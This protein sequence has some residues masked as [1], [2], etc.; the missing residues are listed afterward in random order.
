MAESWK[1]QLTAQSL[2]TPSWSRSISEH[3]RRLQ[4]LLRE[5]REM[6]QGWGGGDLDGEVPWLRWGSPYFEYVQISLGK[7]KRLGKF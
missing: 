5:L 4:S 7:L 6:L 3:S 2:P 1:N